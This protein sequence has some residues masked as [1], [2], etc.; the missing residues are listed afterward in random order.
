MPQSPSFNVIALYVILLALIAT[1]VVGIAWS[2]RKS[3]RRNRELSRRN[4]AMDAM[5][6]EIKD[7]MHQIA[8]RGDYFVRV[9]NPHLTRCWETKKCGQTECPSYNCEKNLRCWEVSG[10]FCRG[11][12]Q[13]VFAKKLKNCR[14]CSV[15]QAA[16]QDAVFDLAES[17]NEMILMIGDRHQSLDD[18]NRKLA[19][20]I[21]RA[22]SLTAQAQEA[23]KAKSDFLANIS[24]ELRTPLH[25]I[26]SYSRFGVSDGPSSDHNELQEYFHNINHCADNLLRL[27]NDLLDLSKMEAGHMTFAFQS[28]DLSEIVKNVISEFEP[29]CAEHN[30]VIV[31]EDPDTAT[32]SF[33]DPLRIQQVV[34]NLLSNAMKYS[35]SESA[36]HVRLQQNGEMLSLRIHDSGP[37]IPSNEL[38][39][40]FDKFVQSSKTKSNE[41]GTGLGLAICREIVNGH[42][43]RIWAESNVGAGSVFYVE[44]PAADEELLFNAS[45]FGAVI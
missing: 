1:L 5:A 7:L 13:G 3:I 17:F 37:G 2:V 15:Y 41:G 4:L 27:V 31:F 19:T 6:R 39:T 16:R 42:K 36:I 38:E 32:P 9:N 34:R 26:L 28:A 35:P 20:E 25:G 33:V 8:E 10:T 14:K 21:K 45:Q 30:V 29:L 43:G 40:I 23:A 24:H 11:E 18:T 44:L 12:V 22:D